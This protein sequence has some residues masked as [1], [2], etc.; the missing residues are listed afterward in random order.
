[1]LTD[2]VFDDDGSMILGFSDRLGHQHAP[3][4]L[5]SYANGSP[6]GC[7]RIGG[8][9]VRICNVGNLVSPVYSQEVNGKCGTN[10]CG[11]AGNNGGETP[12]IAEYYCGDFFSPYHWETALGGLALLPGSGEL[13][14]GVLDPFTVLSNGSYKLSNTT[15]Q[16]TSA[17]EIIPSGLAFQKG[18]SLGDFEVLCAAAPKEIGNFIWIDSNNDGVQDPCEDPVAGVKVNLYKMDGANTTFVATTTS[19]AQG[20]WYFKDHDQFGGF[21]TLMTGAMY[22]VTLGV[23]ERSRSKFAATVNWSSVSR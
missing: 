21:D 14:S 10:G 1:M 5:E 11:T 12:P 4:G 15:G 2:V 19:N 23:S 22:F 20:E 18:A 3:G 13:V 16:K 9:I 7:L 8:D 6:L 17:Y